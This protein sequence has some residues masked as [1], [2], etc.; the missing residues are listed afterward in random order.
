MTDAITTSADVPAR[1]GN[2]E[3]RGFLKRI[4]G[5]AAL[6]LAGLAADLIAPEVMIPAGLALFALQRAHRS[7]HLAKGLDALVR[8]GI[9]TQSRRDAVAGAVRKLDETV[10]LQP[11]DVLLLAALAPELK[12]LEPIVGKMPVLRRVAAGVRTVASAVP[13]IGSVRQLKKLP[14]FPARTL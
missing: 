2:E 12:A 3:I 5:V 4:P 1:L 6:P 11:V 10:P 9:L 8:R 13:A 7:G 14:P